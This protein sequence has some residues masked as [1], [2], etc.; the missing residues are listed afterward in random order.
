MRSF[1]VTLASLALICASGCS[2]KV[3]EQNFIRPQPDAVAATTP[4]AI[5]GVDGV[6]EAR[7]SIAA[8]EGAALQMVSL[9]QSDAKITVLYFGP[10]M[11]KLSR[12]GAKVAQRLLPLGVNLVMVDH[13]GSGGSSGTPS[14][15]LLEQDALVAYD[16]IRGTLA[17]PHSQLLVHGL[18]L[19]S[20]MAA[21][22]ALERPVAALVLEGSGTTVE[23]WARM[24]VPWYAK[25]L[26]RLDIDPAIADK[27]T[28][29]AV[30]HSQAPLLI[31][32]GKRDDQAPWRMS[33]TLF[34]NAATPAE[35]REL[36]VIEQAGHMDMLDW[37]PAIAAYRRLLGKL[38]PG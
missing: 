7:H 36:L 14:L 27:G 15:E 9:T 16:Y 21:Q 24:S 4:L 19:G 18:S 37:A 31:L 22:V 35:S 3:T 26:V 23:D 29:A 2:F 33:Q 38:Q 20:F 30:K 34:E 10:N 25:P 17:V 13:R 11:F 8:P 5:S 1:P 28:L 12:D 6:V 32:A